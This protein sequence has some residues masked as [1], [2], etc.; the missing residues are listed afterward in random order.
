MYVAAMLLP[1][2]IYFKPFEWGSDWQ[3]QVNELKP[4]VAKKVCENLWDNIRQ[5]M[6]N[7]ISWCLS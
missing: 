5:Q 3:K 6:E 7:I 1:P 4:R 2:K